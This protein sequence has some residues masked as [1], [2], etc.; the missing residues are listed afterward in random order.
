MPGVE[1][2]QCH[3]EAVLAGG[4]PFCA[5]CG[6]N[7]AAVEKQLRGTARM[8]PWTSTI[9]LLLS[10]AWAGLFLHNWRAVL[11][12]VG[13]PGAAFAL[14]YI[15]TRRNLAKFL[16]QKCDRGLSAAAVGPALAASIAEAE[17]PPAEVSEQYRVLLSLPRPRPVRIS[18]RGKT[19]TILLTSIGTM[20]AAVLLSNLYLAWIKSGQSF[21]FDKHIALLVG[22]ALLILLILLA[23]PKGLARE[24]DLLANGEVALARVVG[25]WQSRNGFSIRYEFRDPAGKTV[26]NLA[27]D[28]TRSLY[29]GMAVPV[30]YDA[31]KPSRQV[32]QCASLYEI[33]MP[34]DQ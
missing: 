30:F 6:W 19:T 13:V 22:A 25:Q 3:A 28:Y 29:E 7:L 4:K 15:F 18:R 8:W 31:Q 14:V 2:P 21:R 20:F 9:F 34:G 17:T 24:K 10:A 26:R 11:I 16:A 12:A 32:A 27:S 5:R 1:C 23:I 33:V